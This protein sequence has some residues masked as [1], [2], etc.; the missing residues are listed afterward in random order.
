MAAAVRGGAKGAARPR[1]QA[2]QSRARAPHKRASSGYAPAKLGAAQGVGLSPRTAAVAAGAV[3]AIGAVAA[4][5]TGGRA[6]ALTDAVGQGAADRIAGLGFKLKAVHVQGASEMATPDILRATGLYRDQ[7]IVGVDL[8]AVRGRVEAVGWV[9]EARVIRL[10]PDTLVIAVTPRQP[11]AVWQS[12]GVA[13]VIDSEGRV[14][15]EADAG[16]FPE[17]PLVVGAGADEA[18]GA[19]LP[20]LRSRPKLMARLEAVV[21]VD[22]RR[23]DLRLRDGGLI[24]LPAVGEDSAL[25]QLE[26]LD[27]R[28]RVLELG[29]ARIDLRDP[30]LIAVRPRE[31]SVPLE[32]ATGGV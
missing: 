24:Q 19:L 30:E 29:F 25:I 2:S 28:S 16:R 12:G 3:L 20:L 6:E 31:T 7:P 32:A 14:I 22:N 15:P 17:L 27:Q 8:N 23:W 18:A 5:A 1:T 26:Q 13:R 21:R 9:R 4:L 11:L 10:L